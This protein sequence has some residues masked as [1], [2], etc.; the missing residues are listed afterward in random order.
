MQDGLGWLPLHHLMMRHGY[1]QDSV[2]LM[3]R[4][5]PEAVRIRT[6]DGWLPLHLLCRYHGGANESAAVLL[7]EWPEAVY[8]L[9]GDG[10]L[11]LHLLARYAGAYNETLHA[12][13]SLGPKAAG[14]QTENERW[15]PLHFL[16]YFHPTSF[17]GLKSLLDAYPQAASLKARLKGSCPNFKPRG[18]AADEDFARRRGLPRDAGRP[19][20]KA[21]QNLLPLHILLS[22]DVSSLD[23]FR[24]LLSSFPEAL[25]SLPSALASRALS[26][27]C[28]RSGSG[29]DAF[30]Q[31]YAPGRQ[32]MHFESVCGSSNETLPGHPG[33]LEALLGESS[34]SS[35]SSAALGN[36]SRESDDISHLRQIA[37][38]RGILGAVAAMWRTWSS[39]SGWSK[40]VVCVAT[41]IVWRLLGSMRHSMSSDGS[42]GDGGRARRG[43]G[44]F[45]K[46]ERP[47]RSSTGSHGGEGRCESA[48]ARP[49]TAAAKAGAVPAARAIAVEEPKISAPCTKAAAASA[50]AEK[51][52]RNRNPAGPVEVSSPKPRRAAQNRV[53]RTSLEASQAPEEVEAYH[54]ADDLWRTVG[55]ASHVK[56]ERSGAHKASDAG[57]KGA[58]VVVAATPVVAP[59]ARG[60]RA[61]GDPVPPPDSV[62]PA[63]PAAPV[64]KVN[65]LGGRGWE[66][67]GDA[68]AVGLGS[69]SSASASVVAAAAVAAVVQDERCTLQGPTSEAGSSAGSVPSS[70]PQTPLSSASASPSGDFARTIAASAGSG[71]AA[72]ATTWLAGLPRCAPGPVE[73]LAAD[74]AP[75]RPTMGAITLLVS[76]AVKSEPGISTPQ[77]L[78]GVPEK[79]ETA[80]T[81][82]RRPPPRWER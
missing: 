42:D 55:A 46:K 39:L 47:A 65:G 78:S 79:V 33:F 8:E 27:L 82:K 15:L 66:T 12:L 81:T 53:P 14:R 11:A 35:C 43:K 16:I 7:E 22:R 68:S 29:E 9:N 44:G 71:S 72:G 1:A 45:K 23:S 2:R 51:D 25:L 26:M 21:D 75:M 13:M 5:Y 38:G 41:F 48:T 67:K 64:S 80:G 73:V 70:R 30:S 37:L 4:Y 10:W 69:S 20:Q 60:M 19:L 28:A 40:M 36:E 63:A 62:K 3:V 74:S 76:G 59:G 58:P 17:S 54:C 6:A 57:F 24:L 31:F 49:R 56:S 61:G 32:S 34:C 50:A 18:P 52:R 77:V